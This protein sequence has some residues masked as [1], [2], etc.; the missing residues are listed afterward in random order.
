MI[1][2]WAEAEEFAASHLRALGFEDAVTTTSGADGG[3]D[4]RAT[5]AVAQVKHFAESAVGSPAVQQLA[6]AVAKHEV[7][8]FYALSGFTKAAVL[9]ADLRDVALFV[10]SVTGDVSPVNGTATRLLDEGFFA[11]TVPESTGLMRRLL[12]EFELQANLAVIVGQKVFDEVADQVGAIVDELPED[13][14]L[15]FIDEFQRASFAMRAT[16]IKWNDGSREVRDLLEELLK[17]TS[18]YRWLALK[19]GIDYA[20]IEAEALGRAAVSDRSLD[21]A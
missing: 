8:I 3:V 18:I 17:V 9:E 20:A 15:I 6:G 16:M 19:A 21:G 10:Y 12:D 4:V 5:R 11:W 14:K 2:T 13:E 1:T 7:G